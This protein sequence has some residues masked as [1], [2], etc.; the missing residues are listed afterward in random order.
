VSAAAPHHAPVTADPSADDPAGFAELLDKI[1]RERG[2]QC[3]SYKDRCLRR[4]IGTRMR[5]RGAQTFADYARVLDA[6]AAEYDKLLDALT[7]NVT[8]LFRNWDAWATLAER[9]LPALWA[10]PDA[11]LRVWSAGAS[12]GEEAYS[13]AALFH[14]HAAEA[15]EAHRASRVRVL[16]TDIDAASLSAA[17]RGTFSEPAFADTPPSLRARYFTPTAPFGVVPEVRQLVRFQRHD[18]LR[19][20]APGGPWHLIACRNVLIYF[21]RDSQE[22]LLERFADSLV[23]GGVL[24]LGKVE[25]LLGRARARYAAI[26]QRERIFLR[27]PAAR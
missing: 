27:L 7:I 2:F 17:A 13:L 20:P 24:F 8:K 5:A 3:A 25:T 21:D 22:S 4:R 16:G 1:A 11:Q 6:D 19:E 9:A 12:S 15:G 26:D 14:R 10:R 23:P 18:L